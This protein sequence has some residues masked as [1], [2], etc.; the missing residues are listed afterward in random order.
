MSRTVY[1]IDASIYVFRAWHSLPDSL[2]DPHGHSV[3]AVYGFGGFL[4]RL[5][6]EARPTHAAVLFDESLTSSFRNRLLPVY[7]ANRAL[8]PENL[9][10]Q[11]KLC[12][13]LSRAAGLATFASRRYEADDLIGTLARRLRAKGFSM[14]YVTRDKDLLQLLRDGD[15][16]WDFAAERRIGA[17]QVRDALG[18]DAHQVVDLLALTGDAVDNV[19]GVPGVGAKTAGALLR[20]FGDLEG[21]YQHLDDLADAGIRGA[22]RV[23]QMLQ[24]HQEQVLLA[25]QVL[26]IHCDVPLR[27]SAADLRW[28]GARP[29]AMSRLCNELGFGSGF[30]QCFAALD[31]GAQSGRVS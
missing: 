21:V 26:R 8:P 24:R 9:E 5:L 10:W 15:Q 12:R 31:N 7:K 27:V 4:I 20:C 28:C 23:A 30:R 6:S 1:L 25:R 11:F 14:V 19:P 3:N 18:V 22:A 16:Y 2:I 17:D 13:R 29:K